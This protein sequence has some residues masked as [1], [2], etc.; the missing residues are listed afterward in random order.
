MNVSEIRNQSTVLAELEDAHLDFL[1]SIAEE[2]ELQQDSVLFDEDDSADSF[3]IISAGRVGLEVSVP[4][5]PPLLLE[6][7]GNG[8]LVGLSWA[9]EP[10]RWKWRARALVPTRAYRFDAEAVRERCSDDPSLA[11]LLYK[12]IASAAMMRL[13]TARV[14]LLDLYPGATG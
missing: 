3:Y 11:A 5:G 12:S 13:Q 6:T 8:D 4:T 9:S 7:L 10:Y 2:T 14:R 1:F